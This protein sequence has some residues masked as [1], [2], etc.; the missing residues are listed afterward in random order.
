MRAFLKKSIVLIIAIFVAA[1][2]FTTTQASAE[3]SEA[4]TMGSGYKE[5]LQQHPE[6]AAPNTQDRSAGSSNTTESENGE[7]ILDLSEWQGE[8]TKKQVKK[9]KKEYDFIII[10][11]QYGSE[12]VDEVLEHNSNLLDKQNMKFGVYSYS[13]YENVADARYEAQTLYNRAPKASFYIND[14]ETDSV[15]SGSSNK[16]TAA[17]YDEMK[18]LAGKKKVLFYSYENFM[19]NHAE[20]AAQEYDGVWLANY[21]TRPESPHVLWQYTDEYYS[22]ILDQNVDASYI[23][24]DVKPSWF[25]KKSKSN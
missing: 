10:R 7:R 15:T 20:S 2:P 25:T 13:M 18:S 8:L 19:L 14:F 5:Y 1:I 6:A 4:G 9:L 17:W 23:S 16:A 3:Q 22:K 21:T 12:Y 24:P 11:G